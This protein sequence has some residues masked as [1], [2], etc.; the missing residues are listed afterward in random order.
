MVISH[1][2]Y[3]Q[4]VIIVCSYH[5]PTQACMQDLASVACN[6]GP[7]Y[8]STRGLD[9]RLVCGSFHLSGASGLAS[10]CSLIMV[11]EK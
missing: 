3:P 6:R 4:L 11:N 2:I 7:A 1:K 9:P 8:I 5:Q 10:I